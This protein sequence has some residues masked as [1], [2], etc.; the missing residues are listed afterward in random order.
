[1]ADGIDEEKLIKEADKYIDELRKWLADEIEFGR[2][3]REEA[4]QILTQIEDLIRKGKN[5]SDINISGLAKDPF[6]STYVSPTGRTSR[7]EAPTAQSQDYEYYRQRL[8][9]R[10]KR[11]VQLGRMS[12]VQA[13]QLIAQT[14]QGISMGRSISQLPYYYEMNIAPTEDILPRLQAAED[15][16]AQGVITSQQQVYDLQKRKEAERSAAQQRG[17]ETTLANMPSY[18]ETYYPF[19]EQSL[20]TGAVSPAMKEYY[21]RM[22]PTI[23][24]EYEATVPPSKGLT[25]GPAGGF[26]PSL[27]GLTPREQWWMRQQGYGGVSEGARESALAEGAAAGISPAEGL[28]EGMESMALARPSASLGKP[29]DPFQAYLEQYPYLAKYLAMSP[30]QRGYYPSKYTPTTRWLMY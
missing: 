12:Q 16:R 28:P 23:Q 15:A 8:K 3:S 25:F 2:M 10:L 21:S 18:G 14:E 19:L 24:S 13:D 6:S 1:M 27:K 4:N 11:E 29:K 30:E 9:N 17:F 7:G 5:V 26:R 22:L 20:Q